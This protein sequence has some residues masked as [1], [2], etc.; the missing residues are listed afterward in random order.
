MSR[1]KT[2]SEEY[3]RRVQFVADAMMS[4]IWNDVASIELQKKWE[5]T[6]SQMA[7]IAAEA[8]RIIRRVYAQDRD[9][10]RGDLAAFFQRIA[11]QALTKGNPTTVV[12]VRKTLDDAGHEVITERTETRL[13]P[14]YRAAIAAG[15]E[16]GKVLD[17]YP[18]AKQEVTGRDGGPIK[19]DGLT[20]VELRARAQQ[21]LREVA[22]V[23]DADSAPSVPI[24]DPEGEPDGNKPDPNAQ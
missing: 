8:S 6:A 14:D 9:K 16:L 21:L 4:M 19:V 15:S 3:I 20:D 18:A 13:N 1:N 23:T 2:T 24:E 12:T 7:R 17:I 10:T 5:V 22:L 11:G